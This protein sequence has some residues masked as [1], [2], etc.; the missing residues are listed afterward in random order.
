MV[1]DSRRKNKTVVRR[2][3]CLNKRCG[4]SFTTNEVVPDKTEALK[5]K[6]IAAAKANITQAIGELES[7]NQKL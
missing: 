2:R 5:I 1:S 4:I 7:I 6:L 3:R